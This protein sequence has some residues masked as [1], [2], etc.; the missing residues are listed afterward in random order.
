MNDSR[1]PWLILVPRRQGLR[2]IHHLDGADRL[3]LWD[4]SCRVAEFMERR[5]QPD[6]LNVAALGNLVPQ[7]HLHHIARF[8]DDPAWPGPVW[9]HSPFVPYAE[10]EGLALVRELRGTFS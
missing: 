1:Y 6:K 4:E 5:F 10:E 3:L 2:E 9:G 8:Q 7:L